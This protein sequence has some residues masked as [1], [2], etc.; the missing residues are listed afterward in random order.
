LLIEFKKPLETVGRQEGAQAQE[1]R[2]ELAPSFGH[3]EVI[4]IGGRVDSTMQQQYQDPCLRFLSYD[5]VIS[6]ARTQLQWLIQE[7]TTN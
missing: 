2:D 5:A 7:L 4:V 6:N 3:M 1:Y